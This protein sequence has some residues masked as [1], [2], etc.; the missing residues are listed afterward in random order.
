MK[1][2][3]IK[4]AILLFIRWLNKNKKGNSLLEAIFST[5]STEGLIDV[6]KEKSTEE[7]ISDI[8][9]DI[10]DETISTVISGIIEK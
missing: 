4:I 5:N 2:M 3:L 6:L 8:V 1:A 7:S 9:T 10:E